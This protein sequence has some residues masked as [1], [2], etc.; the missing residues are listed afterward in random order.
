MKQKAKTAL[1]T[2]NRQSVMKAFTPEE[3]QLLEQMNATI[4][5]LLDMNA[6]GGAM[7]PEGGE[8]ENQAELAKYIEKMEV[9]PGEEDQE[10]IEKAEDEL[11]A[12]KPAEEKM[13][14]GTDVNDANLPITKMATILNALMGRANAVKKSQ[15][16]G[17]EAVTAAVQKGMGTIMKRLDEIEQ[18]QENML[19]A[20]GVTSEVEKSFNSV[21]GEQTVQKSLPVQSTD[22]S[23][24][25]R[26]I[27]NIFKDAAG[28]MRQE[29]SADDYK[30]VPER[31]ATGDIRKDLGAA[32]QFIFK[33]N[34]NRRSNK[35][36]AGR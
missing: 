22:N 9:Q 34:I 4:N 2:V 30:I 21:R 23:A 25:A 18:F 29:R 1:N 33:D 6:A 32:M 8:E 24:I 20:M 17:L 36:P 19:D 28:N 31:N 14:I 10:D 16:T 12:R 3:T 13:D 35:R 11:D 26:E 15:T 27:L 5:Q 7:M